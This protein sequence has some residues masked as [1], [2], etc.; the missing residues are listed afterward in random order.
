MERPEVVR[1]C[2]RFVMEAVAEPGYCCGVWGN[3]GVRI[4]CGGAAAV[5]VVADWN[6]VDV[7]G[8]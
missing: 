2:G 1:G 3:V 5:V 7:L 6:M 4:G 8:V